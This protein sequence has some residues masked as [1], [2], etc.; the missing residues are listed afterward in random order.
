MVQILEQFLKIEQIEEGLK[1]K[2]VAL[3]A[4]FDKLKEIKDELSKK[5]TM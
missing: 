3:V 1:E 5:E 2:D 4:T